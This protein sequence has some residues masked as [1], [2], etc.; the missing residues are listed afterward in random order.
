LAQTYEEWEYIIVNNC[1]EDRTLEIARE[2]ERKDQRIRVVSNDVFLPIIANHNRACSLISPDS[3]YCK[4]VCAD[5]WLF[6][7]C[8]ARM[9]AVAET[10]PSV[11]VVGSYQLSGGGER[12][13]VRNSGLP[14]YKAVIG[15]RDVCR[16]QLLGT[17]SVLANPTSNLYRS[18]FVRDSNGF[19]PNATA[20]ADV[21]ACLKCLLAS[22][23]GFV[24]QVLSHERL[25]DNTDTTVALELNT[26][27]PAA[28]QDCVTY[29]RSFLTEAEYESRVN[30]LLRAYYRFLSNNVLKRREKA[31]WRYHEM[32]LRDLGFPLHRPRL[33]KGVCMRVVDLMLNPKQTV[34]LVIRR[35]RAPRQSRAAFEK[36]LRAVGHAQPDHA[37]MPGGAPDKLIN[38]RS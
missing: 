19:F 13:Y 7:E 4:V 22:N 3:K 2:Y 11:G 35:L 34:Q 30:E 16:A 27:L 26:Y 20:E 9:S 29:G 28:I 24:H 10:N 33:L 21:S 1:S 8:L 6:P 25:H 38:L 12:W 37:P 23:F 5:D 31:F 36:K 32:R 15:G 17:L 14:Y 18:D